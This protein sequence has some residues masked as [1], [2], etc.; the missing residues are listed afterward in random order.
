MFICGLLLESPDQALPPYKQIGGRTANA[1]FP[2]A[3]YVDGNWVC[4]SV[5]CAT[6][7]EA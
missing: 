3:A 2:A 1:H 5:I 7:K 4:A 6:V